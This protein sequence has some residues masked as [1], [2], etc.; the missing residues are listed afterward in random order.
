MR[1]SGIRRTRRRSCLEMKRVQGHSG[2]TF[3]C[4]DATNARERERE[5]QSEK[6]QTVLI[7]KD[8]NSKLH[9]HANAWTCDMQI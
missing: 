4:H 9:M 2:F 1:W 5:R 3:R 6:Y 8:K 7:S